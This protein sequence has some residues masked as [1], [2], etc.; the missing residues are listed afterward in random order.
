MQQQCDDVKTASQ[1]VRLKT[2]LTQYCNGLTAGML[3]W[4][5]PDRPAVWGVVVRYDNHCIVDTLLS[6]IEYVP[7][8]QM[9][10][11]DVDSNARTD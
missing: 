10:T 2:G 3:G 7:A 9:E 8:P 4:T 5:E 11:T 6:Q 1:R